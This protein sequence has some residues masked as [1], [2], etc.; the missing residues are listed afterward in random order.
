MS[1]PA[2]IALEDLPKGLAPEGVPATG[3]LLFFVAFSGGLPA[4][5][6]R[7][8]PD[9]AEGAPE[10]PMRLPPV[11]GDDIRYYRPDAT[12]SR[13]APRAFNRWPIRFALHEEE[14][15]ATAEQAYFASLA[16][17]DTARFPLR[18]QT[19][20]RLL[21][22]LRASITENDLVRLDR[23]IEDGEAKRT[24]LEDGL[25]WVDRLRRYA[26]R[27]PWLAR[28]EERE[29][30]AQIGRYEKRV[31]GWRTK[32]EDTVR[33]MEAIEEARLRLPALLR[34]ATEDAFR[35]DDVEEVNDL[36]RRLAVRPQQDFVDGLP[37]PTAV[38]L[39]QVEEIRRTELRDHAL[40]DDAG[41]ASLTDAE[42][43]F[44][45]ADL[46][47]DLTQPHQMFGIGADPQGYGQVEGPDTV[48]LFQAF[49]DE[50]MMWIFGDMGVVQFRIGRANLMAGR[51]HEAWADM[52]S[53]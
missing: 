10:P 16:S 45:E 37:R 30:H 53:A 20:R 4:D 51:W 22:C 31:R 26:T 36:Y 5:A 35:P 49:Y 6:V 39:H 52:T 17:E 34:D 21:R 15:V 11:L 19:M 40:K 32:R 46:A 27:W 28:R 41:W 23:L 38:P 12:T 13:L 18:P 3:T 2:Q 7:H 29:A 44:V 9:D 8:M 14:A 33:L 43:A 50:P 24:A 47:E 42:R 1:F 25:R 48:L